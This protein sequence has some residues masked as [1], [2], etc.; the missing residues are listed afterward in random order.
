MPRLPLIFENAKI[1]IM[2]QLHDSNKKMNICLFYLIGSNVVLDHHLKR[3]ESPAK[4]FGIIGLS[5]ED[6]CLYRKHED[7]MMTVRAQL[8]VLSA[9]R[10]EVLKALHDSAHSGGHLG[11][12]RTA[13]KISE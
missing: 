10:E 3:L 13:E 5:L 9:N 6:S 2:I 4:R 12:K 11:A 1:G 7:S 8:L